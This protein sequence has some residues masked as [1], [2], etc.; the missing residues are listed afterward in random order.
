MISSVMNKLKHCSGVLQF[1][2]SDVGP[3][4]HGPTKFIADVLVAVTCRGRVF[5]RKPDALRTVDVG[6]SI[7]P[8]AAGVADA[9][10]GG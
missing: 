10:R 1:A 6:N 3:A 7:L 5:H 8:A 2:A 9:A 4:V